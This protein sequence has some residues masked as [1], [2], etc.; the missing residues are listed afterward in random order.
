MSASGSKP[1]HR[2]VPAKFTVAPPK[3]SSRKL[4][5]NGTQLVIVGPS[6][7]ARL[8]SPELLFIDYVLPFAY[9]GFSLFI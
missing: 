4:R 7:A 8:P 9:I 5:M 1:L 2:T 6:Q 3:R